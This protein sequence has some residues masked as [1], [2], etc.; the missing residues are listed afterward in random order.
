[1]QRF[2][3][4]SCAISVTALDVPHRHVAAAEKAAAK[5]APE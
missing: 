4:I 1:M 5:P 3:G 2:D